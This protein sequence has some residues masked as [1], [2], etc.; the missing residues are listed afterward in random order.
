[1]RRLIK[2]KLKFKE[3]KMIM[4]NSKVKR[5]LNFKRQVRLNQKIFD[6]TY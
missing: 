5:E 4:F 2:S 6:T 1:M 3:V